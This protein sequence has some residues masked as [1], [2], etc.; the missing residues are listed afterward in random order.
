MRR[1][2][3]V[4]VTATIA[5]LAPAAAGHF[6]PGATAAS[7]PSCPKPPAL[8][9][10][11]VAQIDNPY[12]P[13]KPGT[14]WT[15]KGKLDGESATDVFTV[16]HRTKMILG[17]A[18]TVI[19][20]QVVVH[21]DLVEDTED[22]FA[23]DSDGNVWYLGEDTKELDHGQ[24]VSTEGSWEAGVNNAHAGIF[25]PASPH[26]G[27][28]FKQEDAKNVAEDCTKIADLKASVKTPY[29]ASNEALR[30]EEFS[31]L[32]P[33]VLDNKFYVRG[34]GLVREQTVLGGS[35]VLELVTVKTL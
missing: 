11:F 17:V 4:V 29:V 7:A 9:D 31:L 22:W 10:Q 34:I 8:P 33:D 25:M 1:L 3:V 16:T 20:D 21:G 35:D 26:V 2:A 15:Y 30:T 12:L 27:Q 14:T 24:I 32:E 13:L 19:H 28:T 6:L 5:A 18:A 23:Q